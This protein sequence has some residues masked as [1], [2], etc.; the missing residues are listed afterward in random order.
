MWA[1]FNRFQVEMTLDEAMTGSHQGECDEDVEYLC[2]LPHIKKQLEEIDPRLI[3]EELREYGAWDSEELADHEQN[4][5][6]IIWIAA[7]NIRDEEEENA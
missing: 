1:T 3:A 4:K 5:R 6:R 2:S 7:G